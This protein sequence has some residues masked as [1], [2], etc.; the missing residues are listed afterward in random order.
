MEW[1]QTLMV[2]LYQLAER[3]QVLGPVWGI[4]LPVI[5]AFFPPLSITVII[6]ANILIY[7]YIP[8]YIYSWT[9]TVV[10]NLLVFYV[11]RNFLHDRF[12][13]WLKAGGKGQHYLEA[14]TRRGEILVFI[15]SCF[16]FTPS[17]LITGSGALSDIPFFRFAL[18]MAAG[19]L[20]M[21][22]SLAYLGYSIADIFNRPWPVVILLVAMTAFWYFLIHP[23]GR[24]RK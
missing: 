3:F 22:L 8:G 16:P 7:G 15:L 14:F 12:R 9:G 24:R 4:V 13:L 2:Y 6:T 18:S 21:V 1:F 20:I 19:K 11:I 5:E 17:L 23:I 10:G